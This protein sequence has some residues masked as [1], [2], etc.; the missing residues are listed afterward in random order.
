M[1]IA[2]SASCGFLERGWERGESG[3]H[4]VVEEVV[5]LQLST[6]KNNKEDCHNEIVNFFFSS[7]Y[8]ATQRRYQDSDNESLIAMKV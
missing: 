4:R 6:S 1:Y 8:Q 3:G 7:T 2:L 5:V